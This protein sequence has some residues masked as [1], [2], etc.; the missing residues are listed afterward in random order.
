MWRHRHRYIDVGDMQLLAPTPVPWAEACLKFYENAS[1][2]YENITV[3]AT[4]LSDS[5]VPVPPS[6]ASVNVVNVVGGLDGGILC[7]A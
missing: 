6:V 2:H 4:K 1:N 5:H 7:L 3:V